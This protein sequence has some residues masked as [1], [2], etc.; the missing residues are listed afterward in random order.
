VQEDGER[1]QLTYRGGRPGGR[2]PSLL[3]RILAIAGGLLV[4][5]GAV[6]ISIVVFAIALAAVLIFGLYFWWKK[7]DVIRQL[8][9][10]MRRPPAPFNDGD[11]IEGEVVRKE[12]RSRT[13]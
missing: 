3:T 11:V 7:R 13:P 5:A 4:L 1:P 9:A 6:A 12:D 10:Q 2:W 8:R